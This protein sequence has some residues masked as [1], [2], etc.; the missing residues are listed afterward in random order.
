MAGRG[1][2]YGEVHLVPREGAPAGPGG[3]GDRRLRD[4]QLV[5][6]SRPGFA[7]VYAPAP[8]RGGR[9]ELAIAQ[10]SLAPHLEPEVGAVGAGGELALSNPTQREHVVSVPALGW[11]RRLAPGEVLVVPLEREGDLRVYLLDAPGVESR[12]FVSPG[13]WAATSVSG[14]YAL[15]DLPPGDTQL[16]VWHPRFPPT[17]RRVEL[18]AGAVVRADFELSAEHAGE[19]DAAR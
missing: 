19:P 1:G 18:P 10:G 13:P 6:Y 8:A 2:V 14:R 9:L 16:R 3:Y 4:V 15:S 7:V 5:D 12:V 17:G 11:V